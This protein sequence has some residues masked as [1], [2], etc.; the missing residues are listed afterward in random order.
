MKR[1]RKHGWLAVPLVAAACEAAE[2]MKVNE[3]PPPAGADAVRREMFPVVDEVAGLRA[4]LSDAASR[5]LPALGV[6]EDVR[7]LSDALAD[8][9]RALGSGDQYAFQR[10]SGR[11]LSVVRAIEQQADASSA[12]ELS[13]LQL[14]LDA[15]ITSKPKSPQQ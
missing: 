2:L 8:L 1:I 10:A 3:P 14:V 11:A 7:V 5:L 6:S 13:A 15:A 12:I 9:D 4:A